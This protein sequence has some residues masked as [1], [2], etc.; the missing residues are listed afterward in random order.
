MARDDP[1]AAISIRPTVRI[2]GQSLPLLSAN[3]TKMKLVEALG[4]LSSLEL[5]VTDIL[6]YPDGTAGFGATASSPLKLGAS[7]KIFVGDTRE[8][9]EIFDGGIT[10]IEAE[11]G[12]DTPPI[13]TVLA[14][15]RLFTA[16]RSRRTR[17]FDAVSPADVIKSVATE[18]GLTLEFG[19][20][21]DSPIASYFQNNESDLAFMRRVL[22]RV[23][24]DMQVVGTTLQ[25]RKLAQMAR[26]KVALAL[27]ETL[28]RGRFTADLAEQASEVS[29]ASFDPATGTAVTALANSGDYG[30]GNGSTGAEIMAALFTRVRATTGHMEP[31]SASEA[32]FA[33]RALY[34]QRARRFVRADGTAQGSGEI[35]VGTQL[36]ISGMNPFFNNE[37][38]VVE[39]THRF[40]LASGYLTDF[41]AESA[42]LGAGA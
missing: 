13:F 11:A 22:S 42:Y 10:A 34:G 38:L 37:Y 17:T 24:G 5:S 32:D 36:S 6:S 9:Q 33:A 26:N 31:M 16:R 12:P 2:G 1:F 27:G 35:R 29:L 41:I 20:G 21:F 18:H 23:D 14:E 4:G 39:A 40:D 7:I 25:V 15:D 3:L 19:D 30:P 8:P 28:V